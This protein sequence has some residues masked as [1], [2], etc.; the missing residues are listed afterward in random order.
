MVQGS[1]SSESVGLN[2]C[3]LI[4]LGK[5]LVICFFLEYIYTL[6]DFAP[7]RYQTVNYLMTPLGYGILANWLAL[8]LY[9]L[10]FILQAQ[11][12]TGLRGV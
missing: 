12:M 8:F 10:R 7:T 5:K 3:L 2:F 6:F 1:S 9:I 11:A 4:L